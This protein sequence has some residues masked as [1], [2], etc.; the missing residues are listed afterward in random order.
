MADL[1]LNVSS[2]GLTAGTNGDYGNIKIVDG[3]L[4]TNG[5]ALEK[6]QILVSNGGVASNCSATNTSG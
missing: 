3:G 6:G 1:T 4:L 5:E 2:S